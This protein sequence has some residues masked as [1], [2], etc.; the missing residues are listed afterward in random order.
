MKAEW[1]AEKEAIEARAATLKA[2]IEDTRAE[3]ERAQRD[4]DLQRAAELTY[5]ELPRLEQELEA[6]SAQAARAAVRHRRC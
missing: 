6:A 2:M 5:G 4:A 1:Q 3:A